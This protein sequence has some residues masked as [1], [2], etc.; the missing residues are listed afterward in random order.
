MP[1]VVYSS[2]DKTRVLSRSARF[3]SKKT[4]G[5]KRGGGEVESIKKKGEV[6]GGV[7]V[8][9]QSLTLRLR[10]RRKLPVSSSR[11]DR[12]DRRRDDAEPHHQRLLSSPSS[13]DEECSQVYIKRKKNNV[14]FF[15]SPEG[16]FFCGFSSNRKCCW[17]EQPCQAANFEPPRPAVRGNKGTRGGGADARMSL[18]LC[19]NPKSVFTSFYS[20]Q[21]PTRSEVIKAEEVSRLHPPI[22]GRSCLHIIRHV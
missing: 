15:R 9:V 1:H 4:R 10:W 5:R 18:C 2:R 12:R 21:N 7:G 6:I 19:N 3:E 13:R 8:M 22:R 11:T 14:L 17:K 16:A 20:Q